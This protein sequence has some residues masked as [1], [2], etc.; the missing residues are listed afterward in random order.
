MNNPTS[1]TAMPLASDELAKRI[2]VLV[3]VG[4]LAFVGVV[5][6]LMSSGG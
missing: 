1:T 3:I 2:F 4:A 6:A 5:I